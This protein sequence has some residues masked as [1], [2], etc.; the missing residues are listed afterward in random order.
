MSDLTKP[1][2]NPDAPDDPIARLIRL[3]G[4]RPPVPDERMARVRESVH[5]RWREAATRERR[6]VVVLITAPIAAGLM[7]VAIGAGLWLHGRVR[8]TG[9][10]AATIV[11]IGGRVLLHDGGVAEAGGVLA[12]GAGLT[13]GPDGRAALRLDDGPSIRLDAGTDLLLLSARAVELRRGAVYIDTGRS[14]KGTA[15][16]AGSVEGPP[17]P[18][19][20]RTSLGR[21]RDVGTQ[22]EVRLADGALRVSVREGVAALARDDRTYDV[23]AGTRLRVDPGGAAQTGTVAVRG[24][25]WDWVLAVAPP[26]DLEGRT[27]GDYL[28]WLSRETGWKVAYAEPS[29]AAS[30]GSVILHGST[31]NLRPDQTPEAVLPTCGLRHR[32]DGETLVVERVT[33]RD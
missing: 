4:P 16:H 11:R 19:E 21:V 26:F 27:L 3:A 13:T 12:S 17:S 6:R 22:F 33:G 24:A 28:D 7:A 8:V 1:P 9:A 5:A 20:V 30:S 18:I 15:G 10:P 32:L 25:D 2:E 23:P 29:I 14:P 31:S